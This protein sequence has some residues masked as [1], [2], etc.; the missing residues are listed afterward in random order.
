[1][2]NRLQA[3]KPLENNEWPLVRDITIPTL[4]GN[5]RNYTVTE[6]SLQDATCFIG[7][8]AARRLWNENDPSSVQRVLNL[9][10]QIDPQIQLGFKRFRLT[11]DGLSF[12]AQLGTNASGRD[13]TLRVLPEETPSLHE[14][15]M[16]ATWRSLLLDQSLLNG[17]LILVVAPNGQGKTTTASAIIRSRLEQYGGFANTCEDPVELPLQGVWGSGVCM[18]RPATTTDATRP[19]EGYYLALLDA[20][21]QFPAITGGGTIL[22]VGEIADSQTAAETLKAAA[23]GHLVVATLHAKSAPTAVRRMAT[24]SAGGSD[25]M[26]METVRDLLSD[27]LRGVFYQRLMWQREQTGW[28][29]AQIK[30]DVLWSEGHTSEVARA[31]KEGRYDSLHDIVRA[32]AAMLAS[33]EGASSITGSQVRNVL[34]SA[35][36]AS[37]QPS[38]TESERVAK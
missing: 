17:G 10:H 31:I 34:D 38:Q 7:E 15:Q 30:G 4:Q 12:R 35:S 9:L 29:R 16:P 19:G 3:L 26:D 36:L 14:L 13:L 1:M 25:S 21:R 6:A 23:N 8:P 5:A 27:A 24:L 20:L 2:N 28:S 22:F 18:Q 33:S 37:R 11:H 32:Q